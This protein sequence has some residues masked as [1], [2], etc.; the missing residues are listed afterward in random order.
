MNIQLKSIPLNIQE[1][2]FKSNQKFKE[3]AAS[4]LMKFSSDESQISNSKTPV[5]I[6][7][8]QQALPELIINEPRLVCSII[9]L[10]ENK[11]EFFPNMDNPDLED[12]FATTIIEAEIA[13]NN[14]IPQIQN[15]V[16]TKDWLRIP[17]LDHALDLRF[18]DFNKHKD[19]RRIYWYLYC[20]L[21][22][23]LRLFA[24]EQL[25]LFK[26]VLGKNFETWI[27]LRGQELPVLTQLGEIPMP[28]DLNDI[29]KIEE[30]LRS[31]LQ[32]NNYQQAGVEEKA[33]AYKITAEK[34]ITLIPKNKSGRKAQNQITLGSE[35]II[36]KDANFDFLYLLAWLRINNQPQLRSTTDISDYKF[37][38]ILKDCSERV[39]DSRFD[40]TWT[41]K[42]EA[43]KKWEAQYQI[44][45]LLGIKLILSS[46]EVFSLEDKYNIE[47][48]P[49]PIK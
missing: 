23:T 48:R 26:M 8:L 19:I 15:C 32:N 30:E 14:F 40:T 33:A 10:G 7:Y 49:Y 1:E 37:N 21:K 24:V 47:L 44:N 2:Y 46:R 13:I 34:H 16:K 31:R 18:G 41:N 5:H 45:K 11:K 38:Y 22:L 6:G 9:K 3:A 39:R 28:K 43:D 4:F 12:E 29:L 17:H 36:A 20:E 25:D 27:N 35:K 42:D